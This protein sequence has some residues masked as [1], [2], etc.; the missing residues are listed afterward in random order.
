MLGL[1]SIKVEYRDNPIGID[2]A[3]PRFSWKLISDEKDTVQ[4]AC[5]V[6]VT[7]GDCVAWDSGKMDSDKSIQVS[8]AGKELVPFTAY[9]VKVTVWD[10]HGNSAEGC[11]SFETG[12]L[13]NAN[14]RAEFIT[15]EQ[16]D[17]SPI[18][19]KTFAAAKTVAKARLYATALGMYDVSL[20]GEKVG[21][22]HL[23]PGWTSYKHRLQYQTYDITSQVAADNTIA[24]T[25]GKGWYMGNLGFNAQMVNHYGT[26]MAALAEIHI[27]YTDG[28]SDIIA[29]DTSWSATTGAIRYSE[30][31]HGETVDSTFESPAAIPVSILGYPKSNI[32]A[33]E[34]QPVRIIKRIKPKEYIVTPKGEKVID[35]GQNMPGVIEFTVKQPRGT[36][37]TIKHAEI[38]DKHG[39]FFTENLRAAKA[40]DNFI[41]NGEQQTFMPLF[42]FHGFRYIM[43][44]GLDEINPGDF[45]ACVMHSDMEITGSFECSDSRINQLQSNIQWG[46]RGNFVDVPTD[47]P[48]RDERLGWTGDAQVF[49]PTAA[50]NMDVA[51]FF[52]KWLRDLASEQTLE[53]GV[54]H[55]IPNILGPVEGV[56][57]WSDAA[58]IVPWVMYFAYDDVDM[59]KE[60]FP[61]MKMWVDYITSKSTNDLWQ[62]N[63]HYGDWLALDAPQ[64]D[65]V[66]ATDTHYIASAFYALS[67]ELVCKAAKVLGYESEYAKYSELYNKIVAAFNDE[68]ITKTGRLVAET[69]TGCILALHFNLA[70]PEYRA[71]IIKSLVDN[72]KAHDNHL[73]A[74]FVGSSYLNHVLSENGQHEVAE[75]LLVKEDIP[76]WLY[77]ITKG[78][79]TIWERW[80]SV[81]PDGT[82]DDLGMNSLNHYAYGAIGNWLY[83]K[84]AGVN[85]IAP[86]Y[87]KSRL[88]PMPVSCLDYASASVDTMYGTLAC[89]WKRVG[90][91]YT[92]SATVPA[93]TTATL[94]KPDGIEVELGSGTYEFN[95]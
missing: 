28:T 37:I 5:H 68:Y 23:A 94:V 32:V 24:I 36:K 17:A 26:Q 19:T 50:F 59:L 21:D 53:H 46:Q 2:A 51:P 38:L 13:S 33:Q 52:T 91:G 44:E 95:V 12:F 47:C 82:M 92:I 77:P 73:T 1:G 35:F 7:C 8:Y 86:A 43:I 58:T 4:T 79:T 69:Q 11:G 87:K 64:N 15:C 90:D 42:T 6:V 83:Q 74:G 75:A 61:S 71:R 25:V 14:I 65:C 49:A 70:K 63:W 27:T 39:N 18:F 16:D 10:N 56:A 89:G 40:T 31:Y 81:K 48:Q 34:S 55:T 9:S 30:I 3:L 84:V 22:L 85:A 88:A 20:N 41:C 78:A 54:P 62:S 72:I 60:Q 67:T 80:N 29:T 93:N 76:S 45:T 66:G 57:A